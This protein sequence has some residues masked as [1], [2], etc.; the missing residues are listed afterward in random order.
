MEY[1]GTSTYL[2][3]ILPTS[4][5]KIAVDFNQCLKCLNPVKTIAMLWLSQ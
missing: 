5:V 4:D 3:A 2:T 1:L